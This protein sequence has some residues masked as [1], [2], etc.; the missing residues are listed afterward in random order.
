[1][2]FESEWVGVIYLTRK[3]HEQP[4]LIHHIRSFFILIR[5]PIPI[6]GAGREKGC[7]V[8]R[9]VAMQGVDYLIAR[10]GAESFFIRLSNCLE[11]TVVA[12]AIA[13]GTNGIVRTLVV[14]RVGGDIVQLI[15]DIRIHQL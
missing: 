13:L 14:I 1:M 4:V 12:D 15:N 7:T 8:Q 6:R 10:R 5:L 2:D 3:T 9:A 11:G